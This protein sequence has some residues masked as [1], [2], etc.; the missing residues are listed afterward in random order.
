M[1]LKVGRV[2]TLLLAG[3]AKDIWPVLK[4]LAEA[5]K[6]KTTEG[7]PCIWKEDC[8]G[9]KWIDRCEYAV[10]GENNDKERQIRNSSSDSSG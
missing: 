7:P 9:C 6:E 1:I 3:K 4:A 2:K 8:T 10:K 5:E